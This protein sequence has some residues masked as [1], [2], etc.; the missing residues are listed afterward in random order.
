MRWH[1]VVRQ[2]GFQGATQRF[3]EFDLVGQGGVCRNHIGDQLLAGRAFLGD[4]DGF[5]D[6]V[7]FT[8]ARFDF[9]QLDTETAN[10]HLMVDATK[11]IHHAIRTAT[12]QVATAI[13]ATARFA[14]WI[15]HKTFRGKCRTLQVP[16]GH[17]LAA[18]VQ[19]TGHTDR[20]Q[21]EL[22]VQYV[23][24][25]VTQQRADWRVD[26]AAW[27]TFSRFPQ[28]WRDHGFGGAIAIE[29]VGW[30]E[31]PPRQ[32]VTS[33]G[34]GITAEAVH[35]NSRWV[36]VAFSVFGQLLQ[37]HRREHGHGH[38]M[39]VHLFVGVFGQPQAVVTDQHAG[40][41]DQWVHPAFV[42]AVESE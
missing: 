29:Q 40:T 22:R 17:A 13:H 18:Q 25:A 36:A 26:G 6:A 3:A 9:T 34:D 35:T 21:V 11:V 12:G 27:V 28:Q 24:A 38:V 32:V 42:G 33:L 10:F 7:L 8:Q 37:V 23:A 4:Y 2:A 20:L 15:R 19:L 39:A 41:V 30:L 14:E 31:C 16:P 5:T 1:H